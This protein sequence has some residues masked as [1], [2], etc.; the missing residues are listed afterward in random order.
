MTDMFSDFKNRAEGKR[1]ELLEKQVPQVRALLKEKLG[2][3]ARDV[4]HNDELMTSALNGIYDILIVSHPAL[5]LLLKRDMFIDFCLSN[6]ARFIESDTQKE[7]TKTENRKGEFMSRKLENEVALLEQYNDDI[8]KIGERLAD[9][10]PQSGKKIQKEIDQKLEIYRKQIQLVQTEFPDSDD[11]RIHEAALYTFQALR[12][13]FGSGFLRRVSSKS[14]NMALGIASGMIAKQQ[15]K[16]AARDALT[17]LDK[18]LSIFDYPGARFAKAQIYLLLNQKHEALEELRYI[19]S[20]FQDDEVYISARQ[21]KDEIENPP[22]KGMCFV[23]T[24]AFG[25]YLAPEV[26]QLSR[27]RDDVLLKTELGAAFVKSYYKVS[28][29]LASLIARSEFLKA[30]TRTMILK[31]FLRLLRIMKQI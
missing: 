31:P 30:T 24:A 26:V 25:S 28:P 19:I 3:K 1:D 7:T 11:G 5:R 12:K 14:K 16:H 2:P 20:N 21:M 13:V 22:K 23:A 10:D 18:A 6:R 29:P 8:E 17:L 4:I 27:F 9:A 15:E